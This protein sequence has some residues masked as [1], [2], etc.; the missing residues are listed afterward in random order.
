MNS[1]TG[2]L[3]VWLAQRTTDDHPIIFPSPKQKTGLP[4]FLAII[5]KSF[6]IQA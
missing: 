6:F 1:S 4:R 3:I 5:P 2:D